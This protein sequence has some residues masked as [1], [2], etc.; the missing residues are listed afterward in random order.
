MRLLGLDKDCFS[1]WW[2]KLPEGTTMVVQ[3][4]IE[5]CAIALRYKYGQLVD[6]YSRENTEIIENIRTINTIPLTIDDSLKVEVELEGILYSPT[7]N[8]KYLREQLLSNSNQTHD[9]QHQL[10][11]LA[12]QIFCSD[13]DELSDL[14]QLQN[15]GFEVPITLRTDDP[16]QVKRWHSQWINRELF[17][18][19]P[20]NGIVAKCNSSSIKNILGVSSSSPN[21]ALALTR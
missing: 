13:G 17:S 16:K 9:T 1:N 19:F 4:K 15:W 8:S 2:S 6:A 21:W 3:P 12:L 18:N 14:T 10:L 5:G 11:F 7:S 20:T